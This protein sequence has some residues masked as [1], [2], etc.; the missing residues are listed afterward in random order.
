MELTIQGMDALARGIASSKSLQHL[1]LYGLMS[2]GGHQQ[3]DTICRTLRGSGTVRYLGLYS[4]SL[5]GQD[6]SGELFVSSVEQLAIDKCSESD[7]FFENALDRFSALQRLD[8]VC[9]PRIVEACLA[10]LVEHATIDFIG[11]DVFLPHH[12][13]DHRVWTRLGQLLESRARRASP[14]RLRVLTETD[15]NLLLDVAL[16]H[17]ALKSLDLSMTTIN[18]TGAIKL[19]MFLRSRMNL[20][21]LM[22]PMSEVSCEYGRDG[23]DMIMDG[24]QQSCSLQELWIA[25]SDP[26]QVFLAL[27]GKKTLRMLGLYRYGMEPTNTEFSFE[28]LR[29]IEG[30][31]LLC[32]EHLLEWP[33]QGVDRNSLITGLKENT[34]LVE[35]TWSSG[36]VLANDEEINLYLR[37]NRWFNRH[38]PELLQLSESFP[39]KL[40]PHIFARV[41]LNINALHTLVRGHPGIIPEL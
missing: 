14:I 4:C 10:S 38:R 2:T 27:K 29:Y 9:H 41:S 34:S 5:P 17:D 8:I 24:V 26:D 36:H 35:I 6:A 20:R 40:W 30:L 3:V 16:Q 28:A 33:T 23:F 31:H 12:H 19:Q 22:L 13:V 11:L 1:N 21:K 18:T 37:F 25:T 15:G 39:K 32:V 7:S